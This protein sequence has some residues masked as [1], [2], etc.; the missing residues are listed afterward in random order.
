MFFL[1]RIPLSVGTNAGSR[2]KSRGL[3][4][5]A[6]ALPYEVGRALSTPSYLALRAGGQ[7]IGFIPPA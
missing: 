7:V 3:I 5:T 4:D 1:P 2:G 6:S